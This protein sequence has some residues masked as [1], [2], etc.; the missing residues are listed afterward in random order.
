MMGPSTPYRSLTR[1]QYLLR[2]TRIVAALRLDGVSDDE[3]VARA[4]TDNIF[5]YHTTT[6]VANIAQV[7]LRR[8]GALGPAADGL[9]EVLAHG[10]VEQ[11]R[12]ANLYAMMRAYRLVWEF[13]VGVVGVKYATL[14]YFLPRRE[15]NTFM[16]D[17]QQASPVVARWSE[18]GIEKNVQVLARSLAETGLLES[19]R[20]DRLVPIYLDADVERLIRANDDAVALPSFNRIP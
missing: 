8:L 3:I 12:Q 7:C 10:P 18:L 11:A 20:S 15:I 1:E 6:M 9:T 5:Q 2:E 16:R 4:K 17:L 14:D 13:M 19:P